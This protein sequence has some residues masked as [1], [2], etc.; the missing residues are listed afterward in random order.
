MARHL[1]VVSI[2]W[3]AFS[4]LRATAGIFVVAAGGFFLP[5]VGAGWIFERF[6]PGLVS[7]VGVCLLLIGVVGLAAG[8][9]LLQHE[10][11]ARIVTLILAFI[12]LL[13]FPLG[14]ALG[15]YT[16]WVLLPASTA[17]EY[18]RIAPTA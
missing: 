7:A 14:T 12:S 1:P 3:M 6:L 18:R 13:H 17:E 16:L 5:L 9:G 15:I 4:A 2:L 10:P 8:W 11:W